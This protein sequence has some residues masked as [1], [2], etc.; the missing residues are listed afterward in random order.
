MQKIRICSWQFGCW[1]CCGQG[2]WG[3]G[4]VMPMNVRPAVSGLC[5]HIYC[6]VWAGWQERSRTVR[7][8]EES[9]SLTMTQLF[10]AWSS[11]QAKTPGAGGLSTGAFIMDKTDKAVK[12]PISPHQTPHH[13]NPTDA[14]WGR[15]GGGWGR[16][17]GGRGGEQTDR[18]SKHSSNKDKDNE[19]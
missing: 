19:T 16:G 12:R 10:S 3:A 6:E 11:Y 13:L 7:S 8:Q 4:W 17:G 14:E 18:N 2:L 5:L 15:W 1:A 9:G